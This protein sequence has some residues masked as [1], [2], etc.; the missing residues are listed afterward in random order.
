MIRIKNS[1]LII[2]ALLTVG[3]GVITHSNASEVPNAL[4]DKI[5]SISKAKAEK[6]G[7]D[8]RKYDVVQFNHETTK[9]DKAWTVFFN[10]K[11]PNRP[12]DHFLVWVSEDMERAELKWGE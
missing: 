10:G 2:L 5:I 11:E 12:G 1:I 9:R 4:E 6:E 7:I 8:L 3:F